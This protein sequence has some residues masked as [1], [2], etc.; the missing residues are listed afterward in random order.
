MG[1]APAMGRT[2]PSIRQGINEIASRWAQSARWL[3]KDDQI[4]GQLLVQY[5]KT[6][7]SEAF[8]ACQEPLEGAIFSALVE[9]IKKQERLEERIDHNTE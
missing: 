1:Y 4:Y 9:I 5:T 6:N 8:D 3:K 7:A 2:F